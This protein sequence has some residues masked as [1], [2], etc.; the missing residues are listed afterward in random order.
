LLLS[1]GDH[2][3]E[4]GVH[5]IPS[6]RPTREALLDANVHLVRLGYKMLNE[7]NL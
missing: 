1:V 3:R 2:A 4:E 7:V 6:H 5:E